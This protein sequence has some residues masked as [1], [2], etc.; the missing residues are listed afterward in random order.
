MRNEG[1]LKWQKVKVLF[2]KKVQLFVALDNSF[3]H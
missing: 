2:C 1:N 3:A